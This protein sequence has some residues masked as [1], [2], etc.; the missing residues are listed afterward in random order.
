MERHS[1]GSIKNRKKPQGTQNVAGLNAVLNESLMQSHQIFCIFKKSTWIV[2]PDKHP[3][4]RLVESGK[5]SDGSGIQD[6]F[7]DPCLFTEC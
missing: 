4:G 2:G 5:S 1:L 6:V 7:L 3:S